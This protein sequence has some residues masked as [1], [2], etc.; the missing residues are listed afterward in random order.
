MIMISAGPSGSAE[1]ESA[2]DPSQGGVVSALA[3]ISTHEV[4]A[5]A[6]AETRGSAY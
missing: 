4:G 1:V 2:R 3:E 6:S 5:R